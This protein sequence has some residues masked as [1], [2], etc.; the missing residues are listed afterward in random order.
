M[1]LAR[2]ETLLETYF[3]G[4]TTLAEEA[5]L[6]DY[7]KSEDVASSL[8]KYQAL[9]VGLEMA[10][11][12]VSQQEIVIPENSSSNQ[13]NW[14]YGIAASVAV[15]LTVGSIAF[16]NASLSQDEKDALVAYEESKKAL[17]FLSENLNKGTDQLALVNQFTETKNRILK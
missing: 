17:F 15:I 11:Q 9:F 14:W 8:K 7:F 5:T 2:I 4:N 6:R 16:S 3:E 10:R 13:R 1:E 12:E